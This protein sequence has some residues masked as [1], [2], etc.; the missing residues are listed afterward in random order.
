MFNFVLLFWKYWKTLWI[1]HRSVVLGA[2][3]RWPVDLKQMSAKVTLESPNGTFKFVIAFLRYRAY[4]K[5]KNGKYD[6]EIC[7]RLLS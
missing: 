5:K 4:K 2:K 3:G 1:S 6:M 7:F